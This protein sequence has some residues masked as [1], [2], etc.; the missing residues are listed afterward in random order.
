MICS[1]TKNLPTSS[2]A[3]PLLGFKEKCI[4][5]PAA[6]P[7]RLPSHPLLGNALKPCSSGCVCLAG[8]DAHAGRGPD[9]RRVIRAVC[10]ATQEEHS[11]VA[12]QSEFARK[13]SDEILV[14]LSR[15]CYLCPS[16]VLS[17]M[18]GN[19]SFRSPTPKPVSL[20]QLCCKD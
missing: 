14:V 5:L 15:W 20:K 17:R 7:L 1:N 6:A 18:R 11:T 12:F 19:A 8:G 2:V 10:G 13:K 4:V 9:L 16:L 3:A